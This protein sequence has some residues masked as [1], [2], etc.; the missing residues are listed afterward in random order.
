MEPRP[1]RTE[2][3]AGTSTGDAKFL[4]M[5]SIEA[6]AALREKIAGDFAIG[7]NR[8]SVRRR[9]IS[10]GRRPLSAGGGGRRACE[11]RLEIGRAV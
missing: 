5:S 10:G 11:A 7:F 3:R 9:A 2:T 6:V 1:A 4:M 8:R